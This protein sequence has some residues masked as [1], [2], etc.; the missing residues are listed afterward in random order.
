MPTM[1]TMRL[2]IVSACALA[3]L[4]MPAF[5]QADAKASQAEAVR[6]FPDLAK[7]GSDFNK[8]FLAKLQAAKVTQDPTLSRNDWPMILAGGVA[9]ELGVQPVTQPKDE[10]LPDITELAD[11][12]NVDKMEGFLGIKW[13]ATT[14][15]VKTIMLGRAGVTLDSKPG[16]PLEAASLCKFAVL[17]SETLDPMNSRDSKKATS[18]S[19][20]FLGGTVAGVKVEKVCLIFV[21]GGFKLAKIFFPRDGNGET[22]KGERALSEMLAKKYGKG[23]RLEWKETTFEDGETRFGTRWKFL[24]G[25]CIYLTN[26]TASEALAPRLY[27]SHWPFENIKEL[28]KRKQERDKAA[29]EKEARQKLQKVNEL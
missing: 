12:N 14:D 28:E 10:K 26:A 22:G 18:D 7:A 19:L 17:L 6:Q 2:A 24:Y 23:S 15:E 21:D 20:V 11:A 13:G 4:S 5:A 25:N 8:A 9:N 27:Y 3:A 16:Y 1:K 29:A